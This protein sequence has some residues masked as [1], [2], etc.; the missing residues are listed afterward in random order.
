MI[1]QRYTLISGLRIHLFGSTQ[2][3]HVDRAS[4]MPISRGTET[5]L[6]YLLLQR[7]RSIPRE[8]LIEL[9]WGDQSELKARSCLSTT[10]WRLRQVLEPEGITRGTYLVTT[11]SGEIGFN[12]ESDHW[13]DTTV[14]EEQ[15]DHLLAR[16]IL[17][18]NDADVQQFKQGLQLYT[19]DIL[20]GIYEDW[21]L[22]ERERL[23]L[24]HLSCLAHLMYYYKHH[25]AY[26]E[27]LT[28]GK[29]ILQRDPL[30]EEIH[31]EMMRLYMA[32]GQRALAV[33]QYETCREILETELGL[34]PMPETLSLYEQIAFEQGTSPV[35]S[36]QAGPDMRHAL[37]QLHL[38][39][40]AC[41]KSNDQLQ[42]TIQLVD[43]LID[44]SVSP[45]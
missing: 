20:E 11:S 12:W 16:E 15:M 13:L 1:G 44:R 36:S 27:S 5:L 32:N 43:R 29:A 33:R 42:R 45:R 19:G 9:F 25:G 24:L 26:E 39:M 37:H 41:K 35:Y 31:R 22:R 23:R 8:V 30:R 38:A 7:H 14:F 34:D 3:V 17:N 18:L 21:A 2:I 40:Q 6:A 10:L 4:T 28:Y